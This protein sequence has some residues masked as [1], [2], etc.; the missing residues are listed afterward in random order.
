VSDNNNEQAMQMPTPD[1]ALK[2]LDKL[3]GSWTMK[4]R[5]LDS[6]DDNISGR[7]AFEWLPGGFFLLQRFE[8]NFAG[9][10]I[11]SLELIGYDP[12]TKAFSS[13]VYSN[14]APFALP[15]QWDLQDDVLRISTEASK[16]EGTF[17]EDDNTFSGGWRP[18][19][20]MEGPGNIPYDISGTRMK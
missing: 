5:T 1:P 18:I 20:G 16:C 12:E 10:E 9:F 8:M 15:Y 4:G 13:L 19:P 17:S 11:Q 6:E 2:R 3:V 14:L 7:T